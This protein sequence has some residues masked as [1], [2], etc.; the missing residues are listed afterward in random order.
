MMKLR[1]IDY[2]IV[3]NQNQQGK[4]ALSTNKH[5]VAD[6]AGVAAC[7]RYDKFSLLEQGLAG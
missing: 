7:G 5:P 2:E 1:A 3:Q 6:R 4:Q